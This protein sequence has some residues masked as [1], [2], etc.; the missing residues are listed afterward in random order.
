MKRDIDMSDTQDVG[1]LKHWVKVLAD[2]RAQ[3]AKYKEREAQAK[4]KLL[5]GFKATTATI[6]GKPVFTVQRSSGRRFDSKRFRAENPT[7]SE[8]YMIETSTEA[9]FLV[10]DDE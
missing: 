1:D 9:V 6:E 2:A 5:E 10:G 7:Q 8:S 3:I 4:E